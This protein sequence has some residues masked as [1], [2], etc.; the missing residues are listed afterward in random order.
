[1]NCGERAKDYDPN[2]RR[3]GVETDFSFAEKVN[4]YIHI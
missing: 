3:G 2:E 4:L 1:V